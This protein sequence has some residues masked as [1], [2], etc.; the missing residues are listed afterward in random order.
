MNASPLPI[1]RL[2]L[3]AVEDYLLTAS[4]ALETCEAYQQAKRENTAFSISAYWQNRGWLTEPQIDQ[5]IEQ[6]KALPPLSSPEAREREDKQVLKYIERALREEQRRHEEHHEAHQPAVSSPEESATPR[7]A[8]LPAEAT[9]FAVEEDTDAQFQRR[10]KHT[11]HHTQAALSC[12]AEARQILQ[13]VD[14]LGT[15]QQLLRKEWLDTAQ[16]LPAWTPFEDK[17][18]LWDK[19]EAYLHHQQ[20]E[21]ELLS[22]AI[23]KYLQS[24][25]H[26]PKQREV[27]QEL[28]SLYWRLF[29]QAE[30]SH[31]DPSQQL[32]RSLTLFYDDGTYASQLES[33]GHI[34][35]ET[36][37][38]NTTISIF[39]SEERHR[40]KQL[41]LIT[42]ALRSPLS[43]SLEPGQYTFTLHSPHHH[44]IVLPITCRRGQTHY[45]FQQLPAL[46]PATR[47]FCWISDGPFA[48]SSPH[49]LQPAP[50]ERQVDAFWLAQYP[51]TFRDYIAYLNDVMPTE[52]NPECLPQDARECYVA[53]ASSGDYVPC[54]ELIFRQNSQ[55]LQTPDLAWDVP[56]FGIRWQDARNYCRW[57]S[58]HTGATYTLPT[59]NQWEKAATGTDRR[60]FP[61]GSTFDA[62]FCNNLR[63][64]P[65]QQAAPTPVGTY[66]VDTSPYGVRDMAGGVSEWL[67]PTTHPRQPIPT[68]PGTKGGH[69]HARSPQLFANHLQRAH[70]THHRSSTIG[71]RL[72]LRPPS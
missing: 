46:H 40:R 68:S 49:P 29:L 56:V 11:N 58:Q 3:L 44:D 34:T 15:Q 62:A 42:P 12:L 23:C 70:T 26:N 30:A 43:L 24:L 21:T 14:D 31:N 71:F 51:V 9:G 47:G 41:S 67:L 1:P 39:R 61:W 60:T 64:A 22:S 8:I 72:A 53:Q 66:P 33:R 17:S 18:P 2:A 38:D 19:E 27:R 65:P 50:P 7:E 63:S 28:A 45:L 25:E 48:P 69:W 32:Y 4:Q 20:Q 13:Q 55:L 35:L 16:T 5:L 54:V 36:Y 10:D 57:L 37:P 52:N 59:A 6:M